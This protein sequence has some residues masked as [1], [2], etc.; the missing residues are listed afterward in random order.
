MV[1]KGED[2]AFARP[3][4]VAFKRRK[5]QLQAG[6]ERRVARRGLGYEYNDKA[7][8][9]REREIVEQQER[10]YAVMTAHWQPHG[11]ATASKNT[12]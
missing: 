2:Y 11:P 3:S 8:R 12:T 5:L 7:L 4:L 9:R 6:A 10:A 1:T